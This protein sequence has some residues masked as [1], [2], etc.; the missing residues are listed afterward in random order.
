MKKISQQ[1]VPEIMYEENSMIPFIEV[2]GDQEDPKVLFIM[3]NRKTGEYEPGFEG[4]EVPVY[5]MDLRQFVDM[6]VLKQGLSEV[7]YDKV[8]SVLGFE[9]L[10]SAREKGRNILLNVKENV[11]N[12]KK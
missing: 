5:E 10:K 12:S 7:E 1:W 4:E 8:R 3:I 2:P 9:P 6:K 11:E